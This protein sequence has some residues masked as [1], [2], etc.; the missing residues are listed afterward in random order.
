[1][2]K[3]TDAHKEQ[4]R[5]MRKE[6]KT[7]QEVKDFFIG[8]YQIKLND[9]DIAV[10]SRNMYINPARF[11]MTKPKVYG[12]KRGRPFSKNLP[13]AKLD[14]EFD[15]ANDTEFACHIHAAFRV[16]ER[17]FMGAVARVRA[18]GATV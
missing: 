15:I 3:L 9:V 1:M 5:V 13:Q 18:K 8:T 4:I 12:K 16:F 17:S 10:A 14:M 6:G 2:P 7:Y 11:K